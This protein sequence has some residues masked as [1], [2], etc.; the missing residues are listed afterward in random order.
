MT[1][2]KEKNPRTRLL[3]TSVDRSHPTESNWQGCSIQM[4]FFYS[5]CLV[6]S[7]AALWHQDPSDGPSKVLQP[8]SGRNQDSYLF[9]FFL[10]GHQTYLLKLVFYGCPISPVFS[11]FLGNVYIL[12]IGFPSNVIAT[13]VWRHAYLNRIWMRRCAYWNLVL[14]EKRNAYSPWQL[15]ISW[16]RNI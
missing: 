11:R 13:W 12:T 14:D 16:P 15:E 7:I 3:F 1:T 9:D 4:N 2:S 6:F 10:W 5:L 8:S